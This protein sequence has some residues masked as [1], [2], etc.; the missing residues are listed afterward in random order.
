[1][2]PEIHEPLE[3]RTEGSTLDQWRSLVHTQTAAIESSRKLDEWVA[4]HGAVDKDLYE[5][6]IAG[7]VPWTAELDSLWSAHNL[8]CEAYEDAEEDIRRATER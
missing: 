1:M 6:L 4:R 7:R 3:L 8:A 5:E 2:E